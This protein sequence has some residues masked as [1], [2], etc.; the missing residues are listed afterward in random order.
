MDSQPLVTKL[1]YKA[2]SSHWSDVLT[3]FRREAENEDKIIATKLNRLHEEM[4]VICEK[5]C[6]V[7]LLTLLYDI[8]KCFI[9]VV[10]LRDMANTGMPLLQELAGVADSTNIR[11]Q[12]LVLFR[13]EVNEEFEKIRDYRRLSDELTESVRMRDVYIEEFQRL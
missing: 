6:L 11:D 7:H 13:K 9:V 12:L 3:Y 2:D 4:L 8:I 1:R 10:C 5:V